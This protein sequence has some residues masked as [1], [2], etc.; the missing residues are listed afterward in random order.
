[1]IRVRDL[2]GGRDRTMRWEDLRLH[3]VDWYRRRGWI[4]AD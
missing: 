2:A 4:S 3:G 1:M